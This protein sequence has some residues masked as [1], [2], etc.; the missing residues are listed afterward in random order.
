MDEENKPRILITEDDSENQR[1]LKMFLRKNFITD[2][3]DSDVTFY[4]NLKKNKYDVIL[5]DIS[6]KGNKNGLELT[7]E[8]KANPDY[9]DIPIVCLTAHAFKK[10]IENALNAG[11]DIF[12]TKPVDNHLLMKTLLD[13]AKKPTY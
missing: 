6:L 4:E 9:S 11:V 13:A 5:M 10:D 3:C 8:L 1:F 7:R 2:I 12:L